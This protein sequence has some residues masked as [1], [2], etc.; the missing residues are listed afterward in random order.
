MVYTFVAYNVVYY[1][2]YYG[3]DIGIEVC[4]KYDYNY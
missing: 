3:S 2:C 4:Y 1:M